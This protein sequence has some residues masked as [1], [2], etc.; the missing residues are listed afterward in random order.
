M[1]KFISFGASVVA[2]LLMAAS[3]P[4]ALAQCVGNVGDVADSCGWYGYA[5]VFNND[6]DGGGYVFD[7]PW[8]QDDLK[9]ER[10][11]S[12]EAVLKPNFNAWADA[13]ADGGDSFWQNGAVG[14]KKFQGILY[15]YDTVGENAATYDFEGTVAY[16]LAAGYEVQVYLKVDGAEVNAIVSAGDTTFS[17][18]A[19]AEGKDGSP[20]EYGWR[21][22]GPNAN[23]ADEATLGSVDFEI[24]AADTVEIPPPPPPPPTGP[25][26]EATPVPSLPLWGLFGL[27]GLLGLVGVRSRR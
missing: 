25:E 7:S 2:G 26:V 23:P 20:V 3:A 10:A 12:T 16:T 14:N 1:K 27:V 6:T 22:T 8:G 18:S 4:S 21:I 5:V 11:S 13:E 24:T 17:L 19:D 9:S 15:Q